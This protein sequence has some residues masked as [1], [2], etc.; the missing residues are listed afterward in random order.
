MLYQKIENM[1][2]ELSKGERKVADYILKYPYDLQRYGSD[3]VAQTCN[4][5][6]SAVI[7]FCHKLGFT[8]YSD[9]RKAF[10]NEPL[11]KKQ[12]TEDG[13]TENGVLDI[14]RRC[15]MEMDQ[16]LKQ[17]EVDAVS[18]LILHAN[19]TVT[20]GM[21]HSG[22]SAEQFSFRLNRLKID[23]HAVNDQTIMENYV[24][25]LKQGDVAVIFSITGQKGY[26]DYIKEMRRNRTSVV[27]VTMNPAG[28]LNKYV[29]HVLLCPTAIHSGSSYLLDEA[30]CFYLMI[31]VIVE[32]INHKINERKQLLQEEAL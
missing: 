12:K 17:E 30:I 16:N 27:L 24:S 21:L 32:A 10:I 9:F 5:S 13:E 1:L 2:P 23:S 8:G 26:L 25:I 14:Y 11:P 15:I 22:M 3:A 28:S 6:R 19:R 29:D 7:R 18:D 4:V 31:E 20:F